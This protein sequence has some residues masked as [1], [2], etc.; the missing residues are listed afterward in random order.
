MKRFQDTGPLVLQLLL[1]AT[2]NHPAAFPMAA[3]F[4]AMPLER[5]LEWRESKTAGPRCFTVQVPTRGDWWIE[6][7][8]TRPATHSSLMVFDANGV[9]PRMIERVEGVR[10][11]VCRPGE[12]L[13]CLTSA[14]PLGDVELASTLLKGGDPMETELDIEP[15][16]APGC[17]G[18][19]KGGDPME[20]EVDIEP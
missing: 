3:E 9:S 12:H 2:F 1:L 7:R 6:V 20:T 13:V 5:Q 16:A 8:S 14:A 10:L 4:P 15:F 18:F 19:E 11:Q 17:G